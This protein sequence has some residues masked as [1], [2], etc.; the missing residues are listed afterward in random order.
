[1]NPRRKELKR[2]ELKR[3]TKPIPRYTPLAPSTKPLKRGRI[4]RQSSGDRKLKKETKPD[5]KAFVQEYPFC[6]ACAETDAPLCVHEIAKGHQ[7]RHKAVRVRLAQLVACGDCNQDELEDYAVWPIERQLAAVKKLHPED[8]DRVAFNRLRGRAD[9]AITEA[10]VD[11][12]LP[13]IIDPPM[14]KQQLPTEDECRQDVSDLERKIAML[15]RQLAE[16]CE[17]LSIAKQRLVKAE[18]REKP[19]Q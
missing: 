14:P 11:A 15:R 6:M 4:K 16:R 17:A 2:T 5:R 19:A 3:S 7:H 13:T 12:W 1:M 8:Y 10:E 9:N 18:A